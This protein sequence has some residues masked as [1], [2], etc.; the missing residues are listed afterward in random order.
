MWYVYG[1]CLSLETG[2]I[3]ERTAMVEIQPMEKDIKRFQEILKENRGNG[4][5]EE[6]PITNYDEGKD[7][8]FQKEEELAEVDIPYLQ[9]PEVQEEEE[10]LIKETNHLNLLCWSKF[11]P[12]GTK[13]VRGL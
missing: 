2:R 1:K 12:G 9:N 5:V 10:E 7:L 3:L 13:S 8:E 4:A 11:C 6:I